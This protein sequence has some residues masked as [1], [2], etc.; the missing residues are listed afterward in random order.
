[1]GGTKATELCGIDGP[2][3]YRPPF[4]WAPNLRE[5]WQGLGATPTPH[6]TTRATLGICIVLL[7]VSLRFG[8]GSQG[9]CPWFLGMQKRRCVGPTT[10]HR[11]LTLAKPGNV[12]DLHRLCL[13]GLATLRGVI[14]TARAQ[15]AT[16]RLASLHL[17]PREPREVCPKG[18][19]QG[20]SLL[21]GC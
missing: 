4:T 5:G 20:I 16:Q 13:A 12:M 21:W 18:C 7:N 6:N 15:P 10:T 17:P 3:E 8:N 9:R 11:F 2:K 19:K 14:R 1:M